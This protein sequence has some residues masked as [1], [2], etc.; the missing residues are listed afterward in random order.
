MTKLNHI[1]LYNLKHMIQTNEILYKKLT[2]YAMQCVD[3]QIK[4]FFIK[5]SQTI[6]NEKEEL[7]NFLN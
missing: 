3:P 1:E 4:Q 6:L 5:V 7:V 2:T